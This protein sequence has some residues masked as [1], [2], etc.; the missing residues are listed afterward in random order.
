MASRFRSFAVLIALTLLFAVGVRA[1][2]G[3]TGDLTGTVMDPT[4]AVVPG[5]KLTLT[6]SDTGVVRTAETNEVG[7]FRFVSLPIVGTYNLKVEA[8]GFKTYEA[9]KIVMTVGRTVTL[10]IKLEI[11]A[12]QEV[13][14]VEAGEQLVQTS[15]SQLSGLVDRRV[16]QSLPLEQRNQNSFINILAGV[17][18]DE[19][20][21]TTRGPAI[22][23]MRPGTGNFLVE[24]FDNNDQGQGGRGALVAGG[25]TSISP[26]AIQE[27]R[28]ITNGYSA[29]YG[30][31]GGFVND[32]VLKSGTND[33]HGGLFWYNRIQNLAAND[34]FTNKARQDELN[35]TG[36]IITPNDHLVRNQFGGSLGGPVIKDRVFLYG[37][38]EGHI[39]RTGTPRSGTMFT[40][41][42][43]NFVSSGAFRTFHETDPNGACMQNLGM[44]CVGAFTGS[45][46]LG[47]IFQNQLLPG[48]S[49]VPRAPS[50]STDFAGRGPWTS[51]V[52]YPVPVYGFVTAQASQFLNEHRVSIKNDN[53]ITS[54]DQLDFKFLWEDSD[55]GSNLDGGDLT[56]GPPYA[57]PGGSVLAGLNYQRT[58]TPTLL[59]TLKFSYL[60]HVRDFPN[61]ASQ[62]GIPSVFT[63]VDPLNVG[64]GNSSA[65]PQFFTENLFQLQ[66]HTSWVT[67]RHTFKWGGE[68]RRTRN[69]SA[70]EELK[71]GLFG[72]WAIEDLFTDG[73]FSD[74]ADQV[75]AGGPYY[76]AFYY[77]Q[78][79]ID[80]S[81]GTGSLPEFYRGFRANEISWYVQD[82]WK[83]HPRLT[84]NLGLR[85]EYFGPP[86]NFRKGLDSNFYFGNN[87]TPITGTA[88]VFFPVN[89]P[90][91]AMVRTGGFQLRDHDIWQK[92]LNNFAPRFG[93][94]YDLFGNQKWVLRGAYGIYY[95]RMWNNLFENIRFN[96]PF[97]A[98]STQFFIPGN[99]GAYTVP[100]TSSAFFAANP[101]PSPRHMDQNLVTSYSQQFNLSLQH[102]FW[103][104]YVLELN[105]VGTLGNKLLGVVDINTFD[106][107]TRGGGSTRI[108]TSIAG[109]NFR[110]NWFRS[111]HNGLQVIVR[112]NFSNGLQ[113]N[114]NYTWGHTIDYVSDAFNNARGVSLRPTDNKNWRIDRGNADFDIRHRFVVSYY[115]E[116]PFWKQNRWFGGWAFTGIN[117][118]QTG[119]PINTLRV[120]TLAR[121][122]NAD[123][124]S[125]DRPLFIGSGGIQSTVNDSNSP[126]DGYFDP[127]AFRRI[128]S[129]ADCPAGLPNGGQIVSATQWWCN[130]DLGRG[131]LTAPGFANFDFGIHKPFKITESIKLTFQANF[132]NIFNRP[133]FGVPNGSMNSCGGGFTN[134]VPNVDPTTGA[135]SGTFGKSTF[136]F[137]TP[138]VT[139][140][141][142]RI[143]F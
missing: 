43:L 78:A 133:N 58:F 39:R 87:L 69:G 135:C 12:A 55:T 89:D 60:R 113:F 15:E 125:T 141:A 9:A 66:N 128:G 126:A 16:W 13:L 99:A 4:G 91:A 111:N 10:E 54:K 74:A 139:Q 96:A 52:T 70:F 103:R 72:F 33:F 36:S 22:N 31:G 3:G 100:F 119:V 59:N 53:K 6:N 49:L 109:D 14:T 61:D 140:L 35:G 47:P 65:L 71:N 84:F 88:N 32:L 92:D 81:T 132:F 63:V 121:D 34:F 118:L 104:N 112:K 75:F 83:I 90:L 80:P 45:A 50:N 142:L 48:I 2:G 107:R 82:D 105:Y 86:H 24:G 76:G 117:T 106:G 77:A 68:Y 37:T 110:T 130:S 95:D 134:E 102:E 120:G 8:T 1:Q 51:A 21:G 20:G 19:F 97:H 108:N 143:D 101:T 44:T 114:A 26:E 38:Y 46:T 57:S 94:A 136:T 18:P 129:S 73:A 7:L 25:I 29:E 124:Y 11:G 23:G 131:N 64:F 123:G 30:K 17:V 40:N 67:G 93:W 127:T 56:F 41:E 85:W 98:F 138:R 42:F 116:L 137:A 122:S 27:Y 5:A 62:V 115:Y 79:A 28:V